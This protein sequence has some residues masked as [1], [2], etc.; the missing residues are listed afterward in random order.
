VLPVIAGS[1]KTY[2]NWRW[3]QPGRFSR[4]HEEQRVPGNQFPF[5]YAVTTDSVTGETDGILARCEKTKTCPKLMHI[6]TSAEFWQAGASLVGTDGTGHDVAFSENVRA[7]MIAGA[8]HAPGMVAPYCELPAN[9]VKYSPVIR[10]LVVAMERWLRGEAEPP[11]STWP[12]LA[13]GELV[14]APGA[15][16]RPNNVQRVDY[17]R[18][19]PALVG[20]GWRTLVPKTDAEGNDAVGIP[21]WALQEKRGVYLGW[22]VRK[23]GFARGEL[24]FLFGGFRP[25]AGPERNR[26]SL[27]RRV[28]TARDMERNSLLLRDD[29]QALDASIGLTISESR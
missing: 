27:L 21:L 1:R 4:A 15:G 9:P 7:Y 3:G 8:S 13:R 26:A 10:A 14:E 19:P 11:A 18:M 22:N 25:L 20:D 23:D 17:T 29:V 2:T 5:T 16:P 24:C 12:R 28:Q 6:D